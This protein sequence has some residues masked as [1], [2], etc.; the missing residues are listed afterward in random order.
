MYSQAG[1]SANCDTVNI[2]PLTEL[3]VHMNIDAMIWHAR[4]SFIRYASVQA[5]R[6]I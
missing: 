5:S 3:V 6:L 2:Q 1:H 4:M